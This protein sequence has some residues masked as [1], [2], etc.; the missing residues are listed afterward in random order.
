MS[1]TLYELVAVIRV[2]PVCPAN[3]GEL[4]R[5]KCSERVNVES[6]TS[7]AAAAFFEEGSEI[8]HVL[9]VVVSDGPQAVNAPSQLR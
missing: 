2:V 3:L 5:A 8:I 1:L 9:A 7:M 4:P 6:P